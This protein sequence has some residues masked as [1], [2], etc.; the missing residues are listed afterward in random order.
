M[1]EPILRSRLEMADILRAHGP[2]YR[3]RHPVSPEQA[4]VM[5][6]LMQCRTAALGGHVDACQGCGFVR[7]SYN[8][9]RDRHCPKCQA[10]ERAAWVNARLERLLPVEYFHVVFTLPE[11][12]GPLMLKNR[13]ALYKVLFDAASRTL[14]ELADDPRRLGA[15]IGI[16]AVLHTW[17]QTLVFHPHL[18]CVVTGGGLSPDGQHWIAARPG[19]F[20]PVQVLSCL[21]RGK[22]LARLRQLYEAGQLTFTGSVEYL[23]EPHALPGTIIPPAGR[24][25]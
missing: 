9:C 18:H 25:G 13:R 4:R 3:T 23:A 21:F 12:L 10:S 5:T 20:L 17:G 19:Y 7:I 11:Q 2:A 24:S 15:Q 6:N 14:L 1:T 22:F 16:T 8:S